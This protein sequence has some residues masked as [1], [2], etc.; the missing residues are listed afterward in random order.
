[1]PHKLIASPFLDGHLLLRPGARS[2]TRI[3]ADHYEQLRAAAAAGQTL[4]RWAADTAASTWGLDV[5]GL[6]MQGTVLVREPSTYGYC[7]ASWEIN[8][9]CNYGCPHCYL[10]ERPV[11]GLGWEDKVRLLDIMREAGV[12]WL[13]ITGGEPTMD[14]DFEGAYR[15][16]W[17]AGMM[18]TI[19]TNGSLL[20]RPDLLRL[21]RDCPPYRLVISLYG[22]S[23]VGY[24]RV[25][26]RRGSWKAFQRGMAAA[27]AAGLPL[28]LNLVV[29]EANAHEADAMAA[30][31]EEWGIEHHA[32]T[33]MTPT[34]S[35]GGEPLLAQSAAHLRR[36]KPFAGCNAGHTFFHADP[37]GLVSIC[38]VG[39]DDR[40]DLMAE[41]ADGL[42]RLG[43]IADRLMLRTG[44]CEGCAL[45]G[46]CRV[47]RPLAKHYQEARAPL[48]SYCQHG[49]NTKEMVTS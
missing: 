24:E 3:P 43:A 23:E 8:L 4:P 2:G 10:G 1:M 40:I 44:G 27:S 9:G 25:T 39:R 36:R 26:Q 22:A 5:A 31:A 42:L 21:F 37:H 34:I 38:K 19:S 28:R 6:S 46:T 17:L 16:A 45:S 14:R 11:A 18:L 15:Y 35:G 41:G 29:T 47:C 7:R 33:N 49:D 30:L 32:Y 48:H 12:L 13:Q 20:W